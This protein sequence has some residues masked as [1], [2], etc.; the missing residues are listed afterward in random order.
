MDEP[1]LKD[2]SPD[3][4]YTFTLYV[5]DI[6]KTVCQLLRQPLSFLLCLWLL[7]WLVGQIS[8][9]M[10]AAFSAFCFLPGLSGT[11][12]CL[13]D[14]R[15]IRVQEPFAPPKWTN[16]PT[17]MAIQA[18]TMAQLLDENSSSSALALH[19]KKAQMATSDL[20]TLV[21]YSDLKSRD[22]LAAHLE[23]F[24]REA[25]RTSNSLTILSSK[26]FGAVDSI[27]KV[28]EY[29]LKSIEDAR[30][31]PGYPM[32]RYLTPWSTT[33]SPSVI[34]SFETSM[35]YLAQIIR[36][37]VIE[38]EINLRQLHKLERKLAVLHEMIAREGIAI[39]SARSELLGQLW[40][41]LGGNRRRL[42]AYE[43]NLRLLVNLN[44]Y[45][46]Q[47]LAHVVSALQKLRQMGGDVEDLRQRVSEPELVGGL[48]P[49]QVHISSVQSSVER[50]K[51]SLV[52]AHVR[53]EAVVKNALLE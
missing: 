14:P 8:I 4:Y 51:K 41:F 16:F 2:H 48:I 13:P 10:R 11:P 32:V 33:K 42:S 17:L 25:D 28:N 19:I 22:E 53:E 46:K 34:E 26:V 37:L 23:E 40:T 27:L 50:L 35:Q 39:D 44:E 36:H 7:A 12:L 52:Q 3:F 38:F 5:L 45:R 15:V 6:S 29:T 24:G 49:V 31:N 43:S 21:R 9:T 18:N 1:T 47:A 20:A 30:L